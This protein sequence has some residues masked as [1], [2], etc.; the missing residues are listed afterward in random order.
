VWIVRLFL[1]A[2]SIL[3]PHSSSTRRVAF[4]VVEQPDTPP[5]RGLA[6]T[7]YIPFK[8]ELGRKIRIRVT[9]P[10]AETRHHSVELRNWGKLA[11]APAG[12]ADVPYAISQG[13]VPSPFRAC[14]EVCAKPVIKKGACGKPERGE[15]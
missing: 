11:V 1:T 4:L 10:I 8:S 3:M 13:Q 6:V 5:D 12:F 14:P 15:R 9:D 7:R 2:R